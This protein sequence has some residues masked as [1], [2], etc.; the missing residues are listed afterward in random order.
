MCIKTNIRDLEMA[1][2]NELKQECM[3]RLEILKFDDKVIED[4]NVKDKLYVTNM[5]NENLVDIAYN[6]IIQVIKVFE[7][8]NNVRIYHIVRVETHNNIVVYLLCVKRNKRE[9]K[10]EREDLRNGFTEVY[11]YEVLKN[12]K[13]IGIETNLG[14][15]TK[16]CY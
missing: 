12:V 10:N 4:F 9:W 14:K 5:S 1:N 3:K 13:N 7:K 6:E 16:I 2:D 11:S 8:A 15:I